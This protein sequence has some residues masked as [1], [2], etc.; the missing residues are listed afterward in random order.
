[1]GFNV[2]Y[3][4]FHVYC[5]GFIPG[6]YLSSIHRITALGRTTF[7]SSCSSSLREC[8][9]GRGQGNE[10]GSGEG[11]GEASGEGSVV[12][13][14]VVSGEGSGEERGDRSL[15]IP[16]RTTVCGVVDVNVSFLVY[17]VFGVCSILAY[18]LSREDRWA[19]EALLPS[20][21][22]VGVC[23]ILAYFTCPQP[24][25]SLPSSPRRHIPLR[26][27]IY[28]LAYGVFGVCSILAYELSREDRWA[29]EA[30]LPSTRV[31]GVCSI[32]AYFTCPQPSLSLPSS[33]RRHVPL[34]RNIYFLAYGVF[35][36]ACVRLAACDPAVA[37]SLLPPPVRAAPLLPPPPPLFIFPSLLLPQSPVALSLLPPP[38]RAAPL[39]P[40]HPPSIYLP[41]SPPSPISSGSQSTSTA[42]QYSPSAPLFTALH[43]T[44][45]PL[46]PLSAV[47]SRFVTNF[48]LFH[49]FPPLQT[50]KWSQYRRWVAHEASRMLQLKHRDEVEKKGGEEADE[51]ERKAR[52]VGQVRGE[53]V[54]VTE[55]QGRGQGTAGR[56]GK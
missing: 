51:D 53:E 49:R 4:A 43:H 32:L 30:L 5:M 35:G 25:L 23:S 33:P 37:H 18:E 10:D 19:A 12:V 20:T 14:V 13:S 22:V 17:G 9:D 46:S 2:S 11:S 40:P 8:G 48:D 15:R 36:D 50:Y 29:A 24:S 3:Y 34:R 44:H 52:A 55:E 21:R 42:S 45:L 27:N 7:A 28:F 47:F 1:M 39:L 41:F 54:G 31:V 6:L 38:V 26:R 56:E 16:L